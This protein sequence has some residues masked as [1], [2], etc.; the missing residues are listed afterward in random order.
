MPSLRPRD[1]SRLE[2]RQ[3]RGLV[4][5][6]RGSAGSLLRLVRVPVGVMLALCLSAALASAAGPPFPEPVAGQRVYDTAN[7]FS[8]GTVARAESIIRDIEVRTG[9]QVAVYTQLKPASDTSEAAQADALALMNQWGVGRKGFDD[10]LVILFDLDESLRH[11]QVQLYAG[12]GF[13]ATFLDD[14]DRQAIYEND[15]LP[16]LRSGDLDGG[17]LVALERVNGAATP[18]HAQRLQLARQVNALLGF[19]GV[20]AAVVTVG[21]ALWH[22]RRYGRDPVYLDDAS[23]YL[24]AAPPGLTPAA[25]AA[26]VGGESNRRAL[27]TAMLDLAS[28]GEIAFV[29]ESEW[30]SKKLGV[31]LQTPDP[32][33]LAVAAARRQSLGPAEA[34][35]L[36]TLQQMGRSSPGGYIE[37]ER[38]L[39]FGAKVPTF[40]S[41]LEAACVRHH[42]FTRAPAAVIQRWSVLGG[43]EFGVATAILIVGISLPSDGAIVAAIALFVASLATFAIARAMPCRTMAGAMVYAMLA[44]YRRTL[45]KTL[46]MSRSMTEVVARRPIPWLETPDQ[47]V[48][49]GVALG[50]HGE[51]QAVLERT[52]DDVRSGGTDVSATYMPWWFIGSGGSQAGPG[53]GAS[54][55]FAPG[56]FASSVVPDFGG[57][58]AAIGTIGNSPSSSGSGAGGGGFGGG[59]G[60]GG[61]GAGGG[62]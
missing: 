4:V 38:M 18:E 35:A 58:F 44:A 21:W 31:R 39:E 24:P 25:A 54:A 33:D 23:I 36:E 12:S 52:V 9:A 14:N 3:P 47:A 17:L 45:Q 46:E 10:G 42:W 6:L 7:V 8:A 61:G 60:G 11:G 29:N 15:M 5:N 51:I 32:H 34:F 62:F 37:P 2:D 40:N 13:R 57:M 43:V 53:G 49:W 19:G 48:V 16:Y 1:D 59:G 28:R 20:L 22:W 56:L 50:L 41:R 26:I 30:L 27:T 55:G